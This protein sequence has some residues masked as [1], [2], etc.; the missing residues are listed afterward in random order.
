MAEPAHKPARYEDLFDLP[1]NRVGEIIHG[2]LHTHPRPAPRHARA[3]SALGHHVGGPFDFDPNGPGGWWI[4]DEPELHLGEDVLVPDL[5]GWRR[6]RLPELPRTAW[7]E[8]A[9]DWVCEILSPSTARLDRAVKMPLY[10]REGVAHLWLVDPD[11]QTL[12]VYVL[13][14]AHQRPGWLLLAILE[15]DAEVR[16]PPFEAVA[17]SLGSLWG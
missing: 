8:L 16:Q 2:V 17:F 10:A 15:G 6:E 9:P 11:L 4:L 5:A 13:D 1:E 12:E 14:T 3:Y 7:F